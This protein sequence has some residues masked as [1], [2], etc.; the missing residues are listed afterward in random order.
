MG[1]NW[2]DSPVKKVAED[3]RDNGE[4]PLFDTERTAREIFYC[5]GRV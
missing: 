2:D 3:I 5:Y 4:S 1:F